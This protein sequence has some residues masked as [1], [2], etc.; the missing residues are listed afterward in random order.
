MQVFDITVPAGQPF[1]VGAPGRYIKY[2]AGSNGGGDASITLTPGHA[3]GTKIQ[4][5]PGQAYRVADDAK[6][7]DSWTIANYAGGATIVGKVVVGNGKIDDSTVTGVVQMVDGGKFRTLSNSAFAGSWGQGAVASVYGRAA[8]YNP[9]GSGKRLMV[10]QMML[11]GG[12]AGASSVGFGFLN[13]QLSTDT[14]TALSKMSGGTNSAAHTQNDTTATPTPVPQLF[15]LSAAASV[16]TMYKFTEPLVILPGYGLVGW[17]Y[18]LN[19][20]YT[21]IAEWYEEP[22]V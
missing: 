19:N 8:L 3:A 20:G 10:E 16:A 15:A 14:G 7:P 21:L 17:S 11:V 6:V 13:G 9:V 2:M 5:S 18:V 22:N 12:G 4:L 1:T